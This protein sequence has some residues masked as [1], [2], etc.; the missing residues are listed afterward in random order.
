MAKN[1]SS[2]LGRDDRCREDHTLPPTPIHLEFKAQANTISVR[3]YLMSQ[4][5]WEVIKLHIHRLL[6]LGVLH[7]CH[8]PGT[9]HPCPLKSRAPR[10]IVQFRTR[11][12]PVCGQS[13][14]VPNPYT[15]LSSLPPSRTWYTIL[16]LIDAFFLLADTPP[17][18][19]EWKDC[20]LGVPGQLLPQVLKIHLPS[21]KLFTKTW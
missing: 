3:Q 10:I 17:K 11:G 18:S 6:Q 12:Q 14:M 13:P 1:L 15:L 19:F 5:A 7:R 9:C 4:E 20:E 2:G 16:D 21:L 8:Q